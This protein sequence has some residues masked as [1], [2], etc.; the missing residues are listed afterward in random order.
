MPW[1]ENAF[2]AVAI[3]NSVGEIIM[4]KHIH[5]GNIYQY[6]DCID[7]SANCN[8]LGTPE[9]IK[10]AVMESLAHL[11]DYPQVGYLP[12]RAAISEYENVKT[13]N[14]ICGNGAAELIFTLC[15]AKKP[16]HALIPVPTFAEYAQALESVD[17]VIEEYVL[18]Q[19]AYYSMDN[20]FL[21][22]LH[23][24]IDMVF[25][26]NPN[27]P[28]GIL[29]EKNF[30]HRVVEKCRKLGIFLVIDECFLDFVKK[31]EEYTMKSDLEKYDNLFL[32]KAFTKRYSMA[33]VRLGYG[34]CGNRRLL[35]E[36]EA[37]VQPWNLSVMAQAAGI[38]AL[39]ETDYVEKGRQIV[40][41]E[42]ARLKKEMNAMGL[43]IFPSSANYLFFKGP[44]D[45]FDCC[46]KEG[47]LIR[48]CSNYKGLSKGFYR[49]AVKN[50]KENDRLLDALKHIL[51]K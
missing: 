45:L 41:T 8:P 14:V 20:R 29:T 1:D 21:D 19:E 5:G 35:E 26:C 47:I 30:L 17:C 3:M 43:E 4:T 22:A 49:V 38:A 28:T 12:L 42:A 15:H 25:L 39:K 2:G 33:G 27:N 36:M 23:V 32:L 24:G 10:N 37:S 40:F 16:A 44:E 18:D 46:V 11:C 31:P 13:E 6:Q 7:F 9:S 34:L 50:T 48:D 51:K